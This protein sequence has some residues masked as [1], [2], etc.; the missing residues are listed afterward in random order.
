MQAKLLRV[1][2]EGEIV[3]VGDTRPRK[4][5]VRVVS[6][7]NRDLAGAVAGGTVRADLYYRLSAFPIRLPPL[8]ERREDV[9]LLADRFLASAATRHKKRIPGIE[10][11]ALASLVAFEWPGNIRELENEIERA[12]ALARDGETIGR[13]HL[14]AKVGAGGDRAAASAGGAEPTSASAGDDAPDAGT[15][16]DAAALGGGRSLGP[17]RRARLAFEIRYI[18]EVLRQQRGNVSKAAESLGISRVMLQKKMKDYGL[19]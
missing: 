5:D 8:R 7:T 1:L 16:E 14:S 11:D 4:V 12:V 3:P 13:A 17:L 10:P 18:E 2:Q 15:A 6:A 19:R 9:P